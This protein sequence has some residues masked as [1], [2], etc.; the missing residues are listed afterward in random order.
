MREYGQIQC[1]FWTD[2]DIQGLSDSAARLAAYLLT[3]PHSNGLGCYRLPNGYIEADF[4]WNSERVSKG[5]HE[6]F[7]IGFCTRCEA[8]NFLLMPKFLR[9][10]PISND[11]VAKARVKEFDAVPKKASIYKDLCESILLYG[12][13]LPEGFR[14]RLETLSKQNP[15]LPYPERKEPSCESGDSR[16]KGNGASKPKKP[17][18]RDEIWDAVIQSCGLEGEKP[19]ESARGAWNRAVSQLKKVDATPD[20]IHARAKAYRRKWPN[21]SL[22]PSALARNWSECVAKPGASADAMLESFD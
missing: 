5:F 16:T 19:T 14:N 7:Q 1:S 9:W 6:L 10:N 18:K 20:E 22:T 15:T 17:R 8:T 4:G 12:E 3:G 21:I 13:R 11:N 2:P